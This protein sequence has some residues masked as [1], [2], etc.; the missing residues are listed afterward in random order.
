MLNF[1]SSRNH[2]QVKGSSKSSQTTKKLLVDSIHEKK[3][4]AVE[5]Y[6]SLACFSFTKHRKTL[7]TE[8]HG[9][10]VQA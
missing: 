1:S 2:R 10:A 8:L 7:K 4:K 6:S 9:T 3:M 5:V